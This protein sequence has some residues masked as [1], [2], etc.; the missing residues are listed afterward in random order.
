M[1]KQFVHATRL[2]SVGGECSEPTAAPVCGERS[3]PRQ[4]SARV[5]FDPKLSP[6]KNAVF[7]PAVAQRIPVWGEDNESKRLRDR[8]F[9]DPGEPRDRF[10]AGVGVIKHAR[11]R[12]H[13]VVDGRL[14]P[15][16]RDRRL[17]FDR[18][19][20][21][22]PEVTPASCAAK[23]AAGL[24]GVVGCNVALD[25][26]TDRRRDDNCPDRPGNHTT[27]SRRCGTVLSG[28]R[29]SRRRSPVFR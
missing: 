11:R 8:A 6:L 3:E 10:R 5:G 16:F 24:I 25:G 17:V 18:N 29:V 1:Y 9:V 2:L 7:E 15:A 19:M 21:G 20:A 28:R 26:R 27:V 22:R 12:W 23:K 4:P 13:P 14:K